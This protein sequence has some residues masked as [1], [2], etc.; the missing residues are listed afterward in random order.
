MILFTTRVQ[1]LI[2]LVSCAVLSVFVNILHVL[3]L[4]VIGI[5]LSRGLFYCFVVVLICFKPVINESPFQYIN[6][7]KL[8][9]AS[10]L[11]TRDGVDA[12]S[13]A[14]LPGF[15]VICNNFIW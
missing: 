6:A 1:T 2:E 3:D 12:C 4:V 7:V 11:M 13:A 10:E 8:H 9:K 14:L 5:L 15:D